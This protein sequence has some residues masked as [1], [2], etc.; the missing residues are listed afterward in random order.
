[1]AVEN[2]APELASTGITAAQIQTDV[3]L[4]LRKSGIRVIDSNEAPYLYIQVTTIVPDG[5]GPWPFSIILT[6]NQEVTLQRTKAFSIGA[7][8]R[9]GGLSVLGSQKLH[10]L[11]DHIADYVDQFVNDYLAVNPPRN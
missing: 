7:T 10:A 8:W 11:R 4:R 1:V 2:I 9:T 3:E 6:F 5:G